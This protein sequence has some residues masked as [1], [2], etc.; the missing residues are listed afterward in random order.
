MSVLNS[1]HTFM[2]ANLEKTRVVEEYKGGGGRLDAT[3]FHLETAMLDHRWKKCIDVK[4]NYINP[5]LHRYSFKRI[6]NKQLLKTSWEKEKL[7]IMSNFSFSHNVFYSIRKWYPHSSIFLTLHLY[8]LL[9]RK[10]LK[11]SYQVK[12]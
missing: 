11:L 10:S 4:G 9:N 6:N 12:G 8:L 3:F 5:L 1:N 7:L 2:V